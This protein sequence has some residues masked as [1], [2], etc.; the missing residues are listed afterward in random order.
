MKVEEAINIYRKVRR[1]P[2]QCH[3]GWLRE[4]FNPI[5]KSMNARQSI[6]WACGSCIKSNMNMLMGWM[7]RKDQVKK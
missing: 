3:I 4:N 1:L 6:N 7:D 2:S 5:L